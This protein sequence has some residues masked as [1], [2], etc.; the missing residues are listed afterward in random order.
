MG[1]HSSKL[2]T[3]IVCAACQNGV[4]HDRRSYCK[5]IKVNAS[6]INYHT[7]ETSV[8]AVWSEYYI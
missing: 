7:L 3:I 8:M 6:E 1:S 4:L 5:P 2:A